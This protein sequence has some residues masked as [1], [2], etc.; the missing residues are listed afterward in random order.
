MPKIRVVRK[1]SA[2]ASLGQ[3]YSRRANCIFA[4][5]R[6]LSE[7]VENLLFLIRPAARYRC[8][9]AS[10]NSRLASTLSRLLIDPVPFPGNG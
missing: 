1:E 5:P 6:N 4:V 8:L 3:R 9:T 10:I 7:L 2:I